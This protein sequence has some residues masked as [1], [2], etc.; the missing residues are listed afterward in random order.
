[1][2]SRISEYAEVALPKAIGM[3]IPPF[4]GI[5]AMVDQFFK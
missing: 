5:E 3:V 2:K 1:L 4:G